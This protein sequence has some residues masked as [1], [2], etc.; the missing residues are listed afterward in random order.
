MRA[1]CRSLRGSCQVIAAK[2]LLVGE[3]VWTV[4]GKRAMVG[5]GRA[6]HAACMTHPTTPVT[7]LA[8]CTY[9][10]AGHSDFRPCT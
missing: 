9:A 4:T 3:N 8:N 1:L 2:A 6:W 10:A 5:L 7:T